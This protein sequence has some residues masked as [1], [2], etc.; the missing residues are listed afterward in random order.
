MKSTGLRSRDIYTSTKEIYKRRYPNAKG[1]V[2]TQSFLRLQS[3]IL[4]TLSSIE[5]GL[6]V[7]EL[8]PGASTVDPTEKRLSIVDNFLITE[9]KISLVKRPS[10]ES[11]A[12]QAE[13]FFPNP[14]VFTGVGEADAY[15]QFTTH[16]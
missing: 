7:N 12:N 3:A 5:F 11:V 6:L 10:G 14:Q 9:L 8:A 2:I 16:F 1:I 13:S 4:A 15:K